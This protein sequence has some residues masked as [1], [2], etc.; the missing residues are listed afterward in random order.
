M[1]L[2]TRVDEE[3]GA[4][5]KETAR[6]LGTTPADALRMF[7]SAFN[8]YGGFPYTVRLQEAVTVE[9]FASEEEADAFIRDGLHAMLEREEY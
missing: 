2:A 5:F 9:P 6:R 1:Q 4:L 3:Q 7:V 8:S